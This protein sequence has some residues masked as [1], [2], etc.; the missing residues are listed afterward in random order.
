MVALRKEQGIEALKTITDRLRVYDM[1]PADHIYTKHEVKAFLETG[2][3]K[4]V[5][6]ILKR[7]GERVAFWQRELVRMSRERGQRMTW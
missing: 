2:D 5:E 1:G 7:A 6:G 4:A 3:V